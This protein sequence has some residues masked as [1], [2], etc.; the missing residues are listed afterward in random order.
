MWLSK[1]FE[2][3]GLSGLSGWALNVSTRVLYKYEAEV[4]W[5]LI[6]GNV[7]REIR[8]TSQASPGAKKSG[9]GKEGSPFSH[10]REESPADTLNLDLRLP[11]LYKNTFPFSSVT[12]FVVICYNS[13]K[14]LIQNT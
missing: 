5:D 7:T 8:A 14:K 10:W 13:Q 11:E 4:F 9:R 6:E 12:Q 1:D 3:G 2:K